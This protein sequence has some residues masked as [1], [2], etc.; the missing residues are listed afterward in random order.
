MLQSIDEVNPTQGPQQ[1]EPRD[2]DAS[3]KGLEQRKSRRDP[4]DQQASVVDDHR[5]PALP[6]VFGKHRL[7]EQSW[8]DGQQGHGKANRDKGGKDV[9]K[10]THILS[11]LVFQQAQPHEDVAQKEQCEVHGTGGMDQRNTQQSQTEPQRM[12]A[13]TLLL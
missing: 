6:S 5:S 12:V 1:G 13:F 10:A 3:F 11:F 2:P 7:F 8:G 9:G 4:H